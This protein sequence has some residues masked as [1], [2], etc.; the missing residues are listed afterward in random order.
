[1]RNWNGLCR[2]C[3][4]LHTIQTKIKGIIRIPK[5]QCIDC[6][7]SSKTIGKLQRCF[8][9]S[10]PFKSGKNHY[11]WKGG[12]TPQSRY[13]RTVFIKNI[14]PVVLK[15]DKYTCIEC[16]SYGGNLHV[17]HIKSWAEHPELRFEPSNCQTLC[18]A[19]HYQKTF[20]RLIPK[21]L[22]WGNNLTKYVIQ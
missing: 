5:K 16:K 2:K 14:K 4:S 6:G 21:G 13:E 8:T 1:M 20:N 7:V 15:R 19:C 9:C 11:N 18:M 17:D 12:L 10:I 22:V 3:S